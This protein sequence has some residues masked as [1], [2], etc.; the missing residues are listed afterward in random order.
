MDS[1][2][3]NER[4]KAAVLWAEHVT[5]NTARS[6]DDVYEHVRSIFDNT[7]MVE[8]TIICG[9]FNFRNRFMD[10]LR[11]PVEPPKEVDKIKSSV[12]LD[13]ETVRRHLELVLEKWP[14]TFPEVRSDD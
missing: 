1:D 3:L 14:S 5:K 9:Q 11:I 8:L 13:P 7:E 12:D 4:E 6:R 10:S 2:L